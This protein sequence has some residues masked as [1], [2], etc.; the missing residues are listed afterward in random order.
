MYES[1]K[2]SIS[3]MYKEHLEINNNKTTL[4]NLTKHFIRYF[5]KETY[6]YIHI[7]VYVYVYMCVNKHIKRSKIINLQGNAN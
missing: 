7:H 6:I 3:R 1:D 4:H 2:D 5:T